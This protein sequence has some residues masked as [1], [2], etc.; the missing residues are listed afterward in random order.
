MN[1]EFRGT[2]YNPSFI[3]YLCEESVFSLITVCLELL[4]L[5]FLLQCIVLTIFSL[6][7]QHG[8]LDIISIVI[9]LLD[10][11]TDIYILIQWNADENMEFFWV[12]ISVQLVQILAQ[13]SYIIMFFTSHEPRGLRAM[14]ITILC[15]F[16]C[17]PFYSLLFYFAS[18]D[19]SILRKWKYVSWWHCNDNPKH[20][21]TMQML[22]RK[23]YKNRGFILEAMIEALPMSIIQL[24]YMVL[25][26]GASP[27][28]I[29]SILI[30]MLSS[31]SSSPRSTIPNRGPISY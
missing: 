7:T 16:W 27:I 11:G 21:P 28:A 20:S 18:N 2:L 5:I 22:E 13:L 10:L 1:P 8:I 12:G 14:I 25:Y 30:S 6:P 24:S 23:M 19:N 29:A 9:S 4:I 17:I 3:P 15:T 26:N 31:S